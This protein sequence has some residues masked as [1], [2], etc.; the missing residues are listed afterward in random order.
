MKDYE[1]I[2]KAFEGLVIPKELKVGIVLYADLPKCI[3]AHIAIIKTYE[4]VDNIKTPYLHRLR[5]IY[6]ELTLLAKK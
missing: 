3:K 2:E 1:K 5:G 4:E 6:R